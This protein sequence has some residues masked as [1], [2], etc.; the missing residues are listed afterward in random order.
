M[1]SDCI[2][3]PD[4]DGYRDYVRNQFDWSLVLTVEVLDVTVCSNGS[5]VYTCIYKLN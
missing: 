4:Q 3:F 2:V 1:Q 5:V